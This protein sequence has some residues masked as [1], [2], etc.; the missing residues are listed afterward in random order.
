MAEGPGPTSACGMS[1]CSLRASGGISLGALFS[2]SCQALRGLG[3]V[4]WTLGPCF[5]GAQAEAE[6][7][8]GK[9]RGPSAQKLTPEQ[10]QGRALLW[11][12]GYACGKGE[13]QPEPQVLWEARFK[14]GT[15]KSQV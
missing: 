3:W 5:L 14:S 1:P 11:G 4:C 8:E 15:S 2:S 10:A 6:Q 7:E 13:E 12:N 9:V